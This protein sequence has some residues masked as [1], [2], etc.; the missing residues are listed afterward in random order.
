MTILINISVITKNHRGM[1]VFTK[2][3][4]KELIKN[5]KY[6][7]VSGN[8]IDTEIFNI[9]KKSECDYIQINSPLP[10]FEQVIIPYL[11]YKYKPNMCWFPS[12]TFPIIK[13]KNTKYIVTIHDLIFL[14]KNIEIS[15]LYQKIGQ[16]YR[17]YNIFL[18]IR[19]IDIITSVSFESLNSI[20]KLFTINNKI[21]N[22]HILYNNFSSYDLLNKVEKQNQK[23]IYTISG[24]AP[25]K[26]LDFLIKAFLKFSHIYKEYNLIISGATNSKY[27]NRYKNIV[28]TPFISEEEKISL[29]QNAELFVFPSLIEGFGIPLIESLY[30]NSNVLVSDI[31]IFKEIGK[32]YVTYFNPYNYDFLIEYF[33]NQKN[34]IDHNKAR[35]YIIN[36]FNTK[37]TTAKLEDIFNGCK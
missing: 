1:G 27:A 5:N 37:K 4:I 29:I 16:L 7:F 10:I 34:C 28:F 19:K 11:I 14:R 22:N 24:T 3:I 18:G 9:I 33:Q 26:N 12:N 20:Y 2:H 15:S 6:I 25:H 17:K 30:Y 31:E 23:Y 36:T 32:N 13:M 21:N 8:K 35:N